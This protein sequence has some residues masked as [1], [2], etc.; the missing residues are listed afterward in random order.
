MTCYIDRREYPTGSTTNLLACS[1]FC[2]DE[3]R[4]ETANHQRNLAY[5]QVT[6][7]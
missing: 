3:Q 6:K 4:I 1:A 5:Y 2:L 7:I